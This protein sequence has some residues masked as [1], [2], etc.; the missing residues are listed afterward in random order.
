M[1]LD[2]PKF[3]SVDPES[4]IFA[5]NEYFSLINT[6][7]NQRLRIMGFNLEGATAEWF[8]WMTRNFFI[9]TWSRFEESVKN[10]FGPSKYEDP[11]G[12]LLKLLQLGTVED[13]QREF[14]KLMNRRELLV[15]KPTTLGDVFS[16][17]II[18]E[19]CFEAIAHKENAT[20]E[21]AQPITEIADTITSL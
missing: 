6:P 16:L 20:L 14:E 3:S 17:E 10:C 9:T 18:I 2:V 11:H 15:S 8:R 5:I 1:W 4:W 7:A 19:A 21:N 12:A 13:Y